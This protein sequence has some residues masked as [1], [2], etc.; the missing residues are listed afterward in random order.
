[1]GPCRRSAQVGRAFRTAAPGAEVALVPRRARVV[2]HVAGISG[3][4]GRP[5]RPAVRLH[6]PWA[7]AM[8]PRNEPTP[9]PCADEDLRPRLRQ[10]FVAVQAFLDAVD[11]GGDH[12]L[13]STRGLDQLDQFGADLLR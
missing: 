13:V 1:A 5:P 2:P 12:E 10:Q 3:W 6:P 4:K 8:G 11:L 9:G 7:P